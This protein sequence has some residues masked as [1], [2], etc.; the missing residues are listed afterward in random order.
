MKYSS[1]FRVLSHINHPQM[2][3]VETGPKGEAWNT[4][5]QEIYTGYFPG[6]MT[7]G[8]GGYKCQVQ[9]GWGGVE[10]QRFVEVGV[11]EG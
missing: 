6:G 4:E 2:L 11:K 8:V 10:T 1:H 3:E 9:E 5:K 7:W